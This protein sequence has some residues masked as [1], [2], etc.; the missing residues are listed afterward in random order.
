MLE[1]VTHPNKPLSGSVTVEEVLIK[2]SVQ[3]FSLQS[4]FYSEL[5]ISLVF[6]ISPVILNTV[7]TI[8]SAMASKQ[9]DEQSQEGKHD[10]SDLWSIMNI[11]SCN[12]WFLGVDQATEVTETFSETDGRNDGES[13]A[14]RVK[15]GQ[16]SMCEH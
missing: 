4:E 13:F 14:A 1:T 9:R 7:M 16:F 11:F 8:T 12:F 2:V 3:P 10:G 5:N 15:V 6:Q